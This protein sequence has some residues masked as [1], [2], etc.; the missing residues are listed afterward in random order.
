MISKLS[1]NGTAG[2]VLANGSMSTNTS[3]EG[4]IRK[5]IIEQDLVDCM[6]A[7]PGQLFYTTQI[8]VCLWFISKNKKAVDAS[9]DFAKRR[10]R[11]GE[12]LF[13][14]AREM[15]SMVSRVNKE[16]TNVDITHIAQTYHAWRGEDK[17]GAYENEAGYC[18]SATLDDI[19]A[20]DYV[21]TPGRYVG[22]ADIVDDGIPFET[23]M[24]ELSQTLLKQMAEGEK[25]DK[26]ICNNLMELGYGK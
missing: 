13:I 3:G 14:D 20:N 21:L 15:G 17:D 11:K 5:K 12:T 24:A 1:E 16:L 22:A 7:L 4:E 23:K 19:K 25:L 18:K 6:I 2:F 26:S 9:E 10:N 8:P